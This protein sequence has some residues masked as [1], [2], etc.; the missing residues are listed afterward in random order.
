MCSHILLYSISVFC[1]YFIWAC[2]FQLAHKR[3][4]T[5][6]NACCL[7]QTWVHAQTLCVNL[8]S[9]FLHST[10]SCGNCSVLPPWNLY[11]ARCLYWERE[12]YIYFCKFLFSSH[13]FLSFH[14]PSFP[15][16]T[17]R[18]VRSHTSCLQKGEILVFCFIFLQV[19]IFLAMRGKKRIMKS[20]LLKCLWLPH[21]DSLIEHLVLRRVF[22]L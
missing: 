19:L 8:R 12:L 3:T 11:P 20:T 15:A 17:S 5:K 14:W 16:V 2:H 1:Q 7:C 6:W 18:T 21:N 13:C 4:S 10:K 22:A 9:C